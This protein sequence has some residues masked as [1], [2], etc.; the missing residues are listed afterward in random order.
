MMDNYA[1][2]YVPIRNDSAELIELM[3]HKKFSEALPV[4]ERMLVNVRL[5]HVWTKG[6]TEHENSVELQ[7]PEDVPAVSEAVPRS[8]GTEDDKN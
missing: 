5:L 6:K 8:Q 7:R 4:L 1:E 3:E 2:F